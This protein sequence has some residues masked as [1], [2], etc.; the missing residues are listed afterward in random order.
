MMHDPV[1]QL[2]KLLEGLEV[3]LGG[4]EWVLEGVVAG[5]VNGDQI[6]ATL[7]NIQ[8]LRRS[9]GELKKFKQTER[10]DSQVH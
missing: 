7:R 1:R 2:Q 10:R 3:G 9:V 5:T 6:A 8:D 4:V